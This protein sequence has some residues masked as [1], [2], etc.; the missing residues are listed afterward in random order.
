MLWTAACADPDADGADEVELEGQAQAVCAGLR[1]TSSASGAVAAGS[2]VTLTATSTCGAGESAEYQF[3]ARRDGS[4]TTTTIRAFGSGNTATWNTTGLTSGTWQVTASVRAVGTTYALRTVINVS[5]GRV[6]LSPTITPS[7]AASAAPGTTVTVTAASTCASGGTAEYRFLLRAPGSQVFSQA[8]TWGAATYSWNTTGLALGTYSWKVESRSTGNLTADAVAQ[9]FYNLALSCSGSL[10]ASATP[11]N[12]AIGVPVTVSGSAACNG[13]SVTPQLRFSYRAST[14]ATYTVFRDWATGS[15]TWNTAELAPGVYTLRVE[16]R[17]PGGTTAQATKTLT[18][19]LGGACSATT[20]AVSPTSPRDIG[21]V[22]TLTGAATCSAGV[23]PQYR[24]LVRAPGSSTDAELRTWGTATYSWATARALPGTY[25]LKVEARAIASGTAVAAVKTFQLGKLCTSLTA[26]LSPASTR[27]SGA[28]LS[29]SATATCYFSGTA[30]YRFS[31]RPTGTTTWNVFRDWASANTAVH[32]TTGEAVG[33]YEL[34]V[35]ARGVGTTEAQSSRALSYTI[36]T[37]CNDGYR[38]GSETDLDC[39]GS[40]GQCSVGQLCRVDVDCNSQACMGG[41]CQ[42]SFCPPVM[43]PP[44]AVPAPGSVLFNQLLPAGAYTFAYMCLQGFRLRTPDGQLLPD[45]STYSMVGECSHGSWWPQERASCVPDVPDVEPP[46]E[47]V[48][49][50]ENTGDLNMAPS[51]PFSFLQRDGKVLVVSRGLRLT[52]IYDLA[53]GTWS[54]GP[55][56]AHAPGVAVQLDD[57]RILAIGGAVDTPDGETE[58]LVPGASQWASLAKA[59]TPLGDP[60]AVLLRSGH[61]LVSGGRTPFGQTTSLVFV[62]NDNRWITTDPMNEARAW[63]SL[64]ALNDGRALAVAGAAWYAGPFDSAEVFDELTGHW[65]SIAPL[66]ATSLYTSAVRMAD[67]RVLVFGGEDGPGRTNADIFDPSNDSWTAAESLAEARAGAASVL[68]PDGRVLA[69]GGMS[70]QNGSSYVASAEVFDP[71]TGHWTSAGDLHVARGFASAL[72]VGGRVLVAGGSNEEGDRPLSELYGPLACPANAEWECGMRFWGAE[73]TVLLHSDGRAPWDAGWRDSAE[74][75]DF[76]PFPS[77][78]DGALQCWVDP[79][80]NIGTTPSFC[81]NVEGV[82]AFGVG[83][84]EY[85]LHGGCHAD[86][87]AVVRYTVPEAGTYRANIEVKPGDV[88]TV[89]V[90]VLVDGASKSNAIV[91]SSSWFYPLAPSVL[92]AG[93]TI[94][95]AVGTADGCGS[96]STPIRLAVMRDDTQVVAATKPPQTK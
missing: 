10:T 13:S 20:L 25:Q 53:L 66:R 82:T 50:W 24:F 89:A 38:N 7:P 22:L 18:Y 48:A 21:T 60:S 39:G 30:E 56:L 1:L 79:D 2:N 74:S 12:A 90:H 41:M 52:Q 70:D 62:P 93:A 88:G 86:E 64:V 9:S 80:I 63:H 17:A 55:E 94:E 57:G 33:G 15:A 54:Y 96:D 29:V 35:E 49:S 4:S 6:C 81:F 75:S 51:A 40:C 61:V 8:R 5:I 28:P 91:S 87:W 77:I 47:P 34:Q 58:I 85:S 59:P 44:D 65:T 43:V 83:P 14:V 42:F 31:A 72:V 3:T 16:S 27:P 32:N 76:H 78:I 23:T 19:N 73:P 71:H 95:V 45:N 67:G 84:G 26:S 11:A 46:P 69:A 37:A 36:T 92:N 68:L